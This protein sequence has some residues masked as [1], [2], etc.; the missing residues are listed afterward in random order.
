[1]TGSI[2]IRKLIKNPLLQ[3][4]Q[5]V[6]DVFHAGAACLSK[7][8]IKEKVATQLKAKKDYIVLFGFD[9]AFGG[10]STSGFCCAYDSVE[11]LKKFEPKFRQIRYGFIPKVNKASRKQLKNQKNRR[12]KKRGTEKSKIGLSNKK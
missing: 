8:Q 4:Q 11:A 3:R 10:S 2:R 5:C 12:L 6:V 9:A 1:M 7:D